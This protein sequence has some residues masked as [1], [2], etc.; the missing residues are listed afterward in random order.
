[1]ISVKIKHEEC[2]TYIEIAFFCEIKKCR[3][4]CLEI[5]ANASDEI[6]GICNWLIN[7]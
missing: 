3:M 4:A 6:F 1:M 5:H 2:M 7:C